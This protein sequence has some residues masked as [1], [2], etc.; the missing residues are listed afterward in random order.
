MLELLSILST[1]KQ[2]DINPNIREAQNYYFQ[3]I[4]KPMPKFIA[5]LKNSDDPRL[6]K[7]LLNYLL[8]IGE[9]L[10]FDVKEMYI[11]L[12]NVKV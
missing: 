11:E 8:N 12:S 6:F 3:K 9:M 4:Y 1:S 10:D 2:L 5:E 7:Q